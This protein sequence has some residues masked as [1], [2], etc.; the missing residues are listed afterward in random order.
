MTLPKIYHT[1]LCDDD[2]GEVEG[3][4]N[5]AG[6]LLSWWA[7]NDASLRPEYMRGLFTA[8]GYDLRRISDVPAAKRKKW[9]KVLAKAAN[10]Y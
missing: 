8:L 5:E 3:V 2:A 4:F 9:E 10:P 6:E 7:C 1:Q